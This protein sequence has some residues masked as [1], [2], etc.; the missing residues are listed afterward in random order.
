[1]SE[2]S[3]A[4][5]PEES[6]PSRHAA[7]AVPSL[8]L[9]LRKAREAR[10]L[11]IDDVVQALKFSPRQV[12]ALEADHLDSLPGSVFVR[13]LV[14]SYARFL[15]LDPEPLVGLLA[16]SAPALPPDVRPPENMGTAMPKGGV[17]QIPTL[18][19]LSILLLIA[20]A[21]MAGWYFFGD[22]FIQEPV[23]A[24]V[25]E[26]EATADAGP[27]TEAAESAPAPAGAEDAAAPVAASEPAAPVP[28]DARQLSFS[29]HGKSWVEV[30]DANQQ[31]ILTGQYGDGA[32]QAVA[33]RPP[34]Q[35]VVGNATAV[36]L[37]FGERTVDLKPYTRAEVARL[38]LAQ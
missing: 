32:R 30:K 9:L 26:P 37:Q 27:A 35:I 23:S 19:A 6:Q 25:A 20:A 36:E 5:P 1:M 18:V 33:G 24:R 11:S 4:A 3:V 14:R 16:D 29:F 22:K 31:I 7:G 10:G 2:E 12:E 17:R 15:K 28:A 13:G 21:A 8:G 34:F 38:T